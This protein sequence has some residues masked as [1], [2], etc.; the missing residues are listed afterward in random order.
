MASAKKTAITLA[1]ILTCLATGTAAT[2]P[3]ETSATKGKLTKIYLAN[4]N[5]LMM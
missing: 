1:T 3:S 2:A 5:T 4:L